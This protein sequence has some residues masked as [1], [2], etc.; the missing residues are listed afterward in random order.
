MTDDSSLVSDVPAKGTDRRRLVTML[1]VG[2]AAALAGSLAAPREAHAGHGTDNVLHLGE[3]NNV[4]VGSFPGFPHHTI[5]NGPS[6]GATLKVINDSHQGS[7]LE[8][9]GL[10]GGGGVVGNAFAV[11]NEGSGEGGQ[12]GVSG[13]SSSD[14]NDEMTFGQGPAP[15]VFGESGATGVM[16]ISQNGTGVSGDSEDGTGGHFLSANGMALKVDGTAQVQ[17]SVAG[18]LLSVFNDHAEGFGV[19]AGSPTSTAIGGDSEFG[20]GVHGNS[21][22]TGNGVQGISTEGNGVAGETDTGTAGLFSSNDPRGTAL[23]VHGPAR[24]STAGF[25]TVPAG[26]DSVFVEHPV[27]GDSHISVTLTSNPGPRTLAWVERASNGSGFTAHLSQAAPGPGKAPGSQPATS[28]T[29]LVVE[30]AS[31]A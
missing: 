17:G 23:E 27:T 30:A 3:F 31:F 6:P 19:F 15:G 12:A 11:D 26:Q 7:G 4:P 10:G 1:G 14:P 29:Y 20:N 25:A 21:F 24:F 28:L 5:V 16:G 22:G 18:G 13:I 8:G 9:V 2:G